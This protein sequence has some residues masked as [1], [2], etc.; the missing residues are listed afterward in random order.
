MIL[1]NVSNFLSLIS[2]RRK[3]CGDKPNYALNSEKK[4]DIWSAPQQKLR[5]FFNNP[6]DDV[7]YELL[8]LLPIQDS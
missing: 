2:S 8:R 5:Y 1:A 3:S 4:F 7:S 6:N